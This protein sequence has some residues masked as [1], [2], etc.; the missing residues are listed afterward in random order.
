MKINSTTSAWFISIIGVS[1]LVG[2]VVAQYSNHAKDDASTLAT[3][4]SPFH[5]I[6][7]REGAIVATLHPGST[8]LVSEGTLEPRRSKPE[9]SFTIHAGSA[10]RL[11]ERHSSYQVTAQISPTAGL[12]VSSAFDG[13]SFGDGVTKRTFFIPAK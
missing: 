5:S 10:I 7:V 1:L 9:E 12:T 4:R 3:D 13:R 2:I 8:W 11:F 6:V